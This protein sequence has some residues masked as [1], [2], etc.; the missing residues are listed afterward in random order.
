MI[1]LIAWAPFLLAFII[2]GISFMLLGY[3]RGAGKAGVS[4]GATVISSVLA[5]VAAKLLA[6]ALRGVCTPL[7][8]GMFSTSSIPEDVDPSL[9]ESLIKGIAGALCA[10]VIYIPLFLILAAII[11]PVTSLIFKK[12]IPEPKHTATKVGGIFVSM[13]DAFVYAFLLLL[14]IYA[15]LSL[16]DGV[17]SFIP[18]SE[19]ET[20]SYIDAATDPFIADITKAQPFAFMYDSLTSFK[21]EGNSVSLSGAVRSTADVAKELQAFDFKNDVNNKKAV[22]KLLDKSEK[23]LNENKFITDFVCTFASDA[24]PSFE[25]P[26]LGKVSINDYYPALNDANTFRK[27]IPS[28]FD[29]MHSMVD[30]GM[31][32]AM[33]DKNHDMS[34]VNSEMISKAFG[35]TLNSSESIAYFKSHIIKD[36]VSTVTDDIISEGNDTS[37]AVSELK[38]TIMNMSDT[39]LKKDDAKKE[40]EAIYLLINGMV[41]TEKGENESAKSL[42]YVLEG[43]A[44]HPEIGTDKVIDT[45]EALMTSNGM[46]GGAALKD[47]LK[48]N[49]D[50]SVNK[51]LGESSFPDFCDT[52]YNTAEALGSIASG[53]GGSDNL[54]NVITADAEVLAAV[55]ES[56][57][58]ELL[59]EVGMGE[60][61]DKVQTVVDTV[62]DSIIDSECTE[63]EA[64]KEAEA[65]NELLEFV[66]DAIDN[67]TNTE[68]AIMNRADDI[69]DKCVDS[70]IVSSA[71]SELTQSG[72]S[73][74][75]DLFSDIKDEAKAEI[76]EKIDTYISENGESQTL[77]DL[78]TF[79][80]LH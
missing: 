21:F 62:F 48:E 2:C 22:N 27:D 7:V 5:L 79:L 40:G 72:E 76:N 10:T 78:K 29:L 16:A 74:P 50:S 1:T 59:S 17:K 34:K 4:V 73:D 31:L 25:I 12:I 45:A 77:T 44:R 13:A 70:Q 18:K 58:D 54:K 75:L 63:E 15:T 36:F 37:G 68:E 11:K 47:K 51:P 20:L 64:E 80:G 32:E 39:P 42:G 66:N 67:K 19:S 14:P 3:K 71:L 46:T 49:L 8:E 9:V 35:E 61:S 26:G 55:K 28:L 30:S 24:I 38:D 41:L 33:V 23:F 60:Q 57:S 69:I 52:A 56:V 43:L 53:D 65:L 6:L